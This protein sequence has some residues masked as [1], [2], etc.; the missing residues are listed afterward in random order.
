LQAS[1]ANERKHL[2]DGSLA[3]TP[4]VSMSVGGDLTYDV[5]LTARGEESSHRT[6]QKPW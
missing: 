3:Y 4:C 5:I 1:V 6:P 2:F